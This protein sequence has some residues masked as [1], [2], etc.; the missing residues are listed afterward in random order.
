MKALPVV[1]L[2]AFVAFLA[3]AARGPAS[4]VRLIP[5]ASQKTGPLLGITYRREVASLVR[6]NARSLQPR[7]GSRLVLGGGVTGWGFSPDHARLV[8]GREARKLAVLRFIEPRSLAS[9]GRLVLGRGWPQKLAWVTPS[10]LLV[11]QVNDGS[12]EVVT[13]D[14]QARTILS[15][16]TLPGDVV[17]A[18]R[19][20]GR[21]VLLLAPRGRVGPATLAVADAE[22]NLG[23]VALDRTSAGFEGSVDGGPGTP[24]PR[25]RI[26]GLAVD[27]QG[28][29]AIV[30][31]AGEPVAEVALG[32]LALTYHTTARP[33]LLTRVWNWLEPAAIAKGADGPVRNARWLGNGLVAVAGADEQ[34]RDDSDRRLISWAPSGLQLL[35]TATWSLRTIA[36]RADSFARVPSGLLA[37]GSS[38]DAETGIERSIGLAGFGADGS[39][40]FRAFK[41]QSVYVELVYGGRAFVRA[42][43]GNLVLNSGS[44]RVVGQ[45]DA[46][47]W[48][49]LGD[50]S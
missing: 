49:L 41:G 36:P 42:Q 6:L 18:E 23:T 10:R 40:R 45:Y 13:V 30:V 17:T 32:S 29:R 28:Q 14:A 48:V 11:L 26:P 27:P 21:L 4:S 2:A 8:I 50:G 38:S 15:R 16:R 24:I 1:L 5:T 25:Q 31:G 43:T 20:P 9:A 33:G 46:V 19:A 35:D 12:A 44:G 34:V 7:V 22:G 47:P 39:L 3:G 37:T